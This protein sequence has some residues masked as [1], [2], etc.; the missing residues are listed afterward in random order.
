MPFS[1]W[2]F[3]FLAGGLATVAVGVLLA[4]SSGG[5]W[6]GWGQNIQEGGRTARTKLAS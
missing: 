1:T 2:T 6:V 4:P 3:W 5:E